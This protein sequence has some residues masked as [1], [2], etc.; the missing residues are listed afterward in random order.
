MDS[1][2]IKSADLE[3]EFFV[4]NFYCF[5]CYLDAGKVRGTLGVVCR[6]FKCRVTVLDAFL[7]FLST[8]RRCSWKRSPIANDLFGYL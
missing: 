7:S 8:P 1:V 2:G 5:L 6:K 3:D 4:L